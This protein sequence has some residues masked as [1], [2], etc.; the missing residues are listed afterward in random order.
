[1]EL[2]DTQLMALLRLHT[3]EVHFQVQL[4]WDR[5]KGSLAFNAALLVAGHALGNRLLLGF[6]VLG[7]C[8]GAGMVVLGHGYYRNA[9]DRRMD[10]ERA[11][12]RDFGAAVGFV[13]TRGQRGEKRDTWMGRHW[14][15]IHSILVLLHVMLA[16]VAAIG[17]VSAWPR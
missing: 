10:I 2:T 15:K 11:F 13:S 16:L 8:L 5:A 14:P 3:E 4:N 17:A 7:A 12:G 6:V 1:M 9:R